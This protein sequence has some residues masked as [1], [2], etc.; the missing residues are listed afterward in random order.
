M[1]NKEKLRNYVK[2]L[3][4]EQYILSMKCRMF[5]YTKFS[6]DN[7]EL[8]LISL[9]VRM[10]NTLT[11]TTNISNNQ[12]TKIYAYYNLEMRCHGAC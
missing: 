8:I 2:F 6:G 12:S 1:Y 5:Q 11:W 7:I 4:A 9:S 3:I 10:P